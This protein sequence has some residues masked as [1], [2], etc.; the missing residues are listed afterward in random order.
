MT[1]HAVP[2]HDLER[3]WRTPMGKALVEAVLDDE[4]EGNVVTIRGRDALVLTGDWPRVSALV[5]GLLRA[6]FPGPEGRAPR[7]YGDTGGGWRR[8]TTPPPAVDLPD[9]PPGAEAL[10]HV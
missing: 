6:R 9:D 3:V 2:L 1:R 7:V 8:V 4:G 5:A 10:L